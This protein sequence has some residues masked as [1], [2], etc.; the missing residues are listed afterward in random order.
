MH[1]GKRSTGKLPTR[2]RKP[3][4]VVRPER[5]FEALEPRTVLSTG[6]L[7]L[8]LASDLAGSALAQD[9]NLIGPWAAMVDATNTHALWVVDGGSGV[10]TQY[11]GA[12]GSSP[13]PFQT[14]SSAIAGLG[15]QPMGEAINSSSTNFVIHSGS[16]NG[17]A[18]LLFASEDGRI[19]GWN[20]SVSS[21]A[22]TAYGPSGAVYT[23]LALEN[24]ATR[25]LLYAAD[26]HDGRIDAFDS[27]FHPAN[28][29][30]SFVDP[31]LPAGDAPFNIANLGGNLLVAYAPQSGVAG[32]VVDEFDYNGNFVKRLV[33][34]GPLNS[35]WGMALAPQTFADFGG[36]L[37]VANTGDGRI[38]AF[39]PS[40]GAFQGTVSN[41]AGSPLVVNGLHGLS[42]GDDINAGSSTILFYTAAGA[43]GQHGVLGEV[44]SALNNPFP[45]LGDA[46]TATANVTVSGMVAVFNDVHGSASQ[47]SASILWGDGS[48]P[49]P[50][51]VVAL[52]S[53]GFG[54]MGSHTYTTG[55]ISP[56][57]RTVTVRIQDPAN[58]V[59]TATAS[60]NVLPPQLVVTPAT[61]TATEG[62]QFSGAIATFSDQDGNTSSSEYQA[63]IDWGD[64]TMTTGT[65]T[66]IATFTVS[67]M[68][69]YAATGTEP[70]TVTI[71]DADGY[72][73]G[74]ATSTANIVSSLTGIPVT[75][76]PTE[77]APFSG[78]VASFNDANTGRLLTAYSATID[79]GDGTPPTP[80]TAITPNGHGGYDISGTHTYADERFQNVSVAISDPGSTITVVS[81][82]T[83]ADID[84]LTAAGSPVSGSEG[85][86]ITGT[87][88]TFTDTYGGATAD[89]FA[90]SI[91]WGDGTVTP[92]TVS[93]SAGV[94]TVAGTH[95]YLDEGS[96][97]VKT[98]V[99]D[100]GGTASAT[101]QSTASMADADVFT[102][103]P[104]S[105]S[106]VATQSFTAALVTVVDA[107]VNG[108]AGDFTASIN[109]GD[110]MT[111]NG[112][113]VG[114]SGHLTVVG[115]HTYASEGPH[116]AIV[117]LID[118]PPGTA[119]ATATVAVQVSDAPI[120]LT[121]IAVSGPER[122]SL[123]V[124]VASFTQPG[125]SAGADSYTA[126]I[127]WGDGTTTPG[128]VTS[129]GAGFAISGT[130]TYA[131]ERTY[132]ISVT[133]S[134]IGGQTATAG[135]SA[136]IVEPLLSNGTAGTADARW[137][138][139]IYGDLLN[140]NADP[141]ALVWWSGQLAA[142]VSRTQV[143]AQIEAGAEYQG[144]EVQAIF[145]TYLHRSADPGAIV[146]GTQYLATHSVEQFNALVVG[147]P[148]YYQ[149]RGGGSND[150]FLN[151]LFSDT[152]HRPVDAGGRQYFDGLLGVGAT[153]SQ[154]AA[155]IFG[156]GEYLNDLV[157]S[158]YLSL[159]DRPAD[160]G[161][162]A[163]FANLL[164]FGASDNDVIALLAAS[165]EDYN[166]TAS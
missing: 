90:A 164:Q 44:V 8:S 139:E 64:G 42:F 115:S 62:L 61:V 69:T 59:V 137:I 110:G 13:T 161:G 55:S 80:A 66:G 53:G 153:T 28:L 165:P 18:E 32:G 24:D 131:D 17:S 152:L 54:V 148:E 102:M 124:P 141:G 30:G 38:N 63:K 155:F 73:P 4:R 12:V 58:T 15:S 43:G 78:T 56:P 101:A 144:D 132:S 163:A 39:D 68:H 114:G 5:T 126:T 86:S 10:A 93:L 36:D 2:R 67:G 83:I 21:S 1:F 103:L 96:F 105:V 100:I 107:N 70:I 146:F 19:L 89:G 92:G 57:L 72:T 51:T 134:R 26:F 151:A 81:R 11:T 128:T 104:A 3:P 109:W 25:H 154:I 156:S 119:N 162:Q 29:A 85:T 135:G 46:L 74:T 116:S 142:G 7:Q 37:L 130:H 84:T 91:D 122:S 88:A 149:T 71:T 97:N 33:T 35:P 76:T 65:V 47:F 27:S 34:D 77:T 113:V 133:A 79:W 121:P 60:A 99:Q 118:D 16:S 158:F 31:N 112:T 117:T 157:Q 140:R 143:V 160:P 136:T 138:N 49:A 45:T 147:S 145:E 23:G 52:P 111:T 108:Q 150:G 106:A 129:S 50:A 82:A 98:I 75:F 120:T 159:L 41:P 22:V 123:S 40:S 87:V 94:F 9:P 6:Y 127:A 125:S 95:T 14:Y 20:P 48:G 166:K